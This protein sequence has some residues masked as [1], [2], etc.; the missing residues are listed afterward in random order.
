MS[1][2]VFLNIPN[3]RRRRGIKTTNLN[4]RAK[5]WRRQIKTH[6]IH[7][8]FLF[9]TLL[10]F[11]FYFVAVQI[12][13]TLNGSKSIKNVTNIECVEVENFISFVCLNLLSPLSPPVSAVS[14]QRHEHIC[15]YSNAQESQRDEKGSV[16]ESKSTFAQKVYVSVYS[17]VTTKVSIHLEFNEMKSIKLSHQFVLL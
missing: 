10:S 12:T 13:R 7:F 16:V 5:K 9:M 6:S 4:A 8:S 2:F 1:S 17:V 11:C 15:I 14:P 3:E